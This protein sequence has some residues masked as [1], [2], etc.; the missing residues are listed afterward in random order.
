MRQ[1][2]RAWTQNKAMMFNRLCLHGSVKALEGNASMCPA[3]PCSSIMQ[4][5]VIET[6]T[7]LLNVCDFRSFHSRRISILQSIFILQS[8]ETFQDSRQNTA[9]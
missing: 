5:R 1:L 2:L 6:N 8:A 9:N 3:F 4:R 7:K